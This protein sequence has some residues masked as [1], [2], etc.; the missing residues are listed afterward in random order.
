MLSL[1]LY[2]CSNLIIFISIFTWLLHY[3]RFKSQNIEFLSKFKENSLK[4]IYNFSFSLITSFFLAYRHFKLLYLSHSFLFKPKFI[5]WIVLIS[6]ISLDKPY[7][8]KIIEIA[9]DRCIA[10]QNSS[11]SEFRIFHMKQYQKAMHSKEDL[12]EFICSIPL[13]C[14]FKLYNEIILN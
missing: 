5:N 12:N 4:N 1:I 6:W 2:Y 8:F 7:F 11:D 3:L 14:I 9:K 10:S 13:N